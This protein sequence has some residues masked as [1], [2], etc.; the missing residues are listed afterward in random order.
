M[1]SGCCLESG[2]LSSWL[3]TL[4]FVSLFHM[5]YVLN[6]FLMWCRSTRFIANCCVLDRSCKIKTW[7]KF[8]LWQ[9]QG[10]AQTNKEYWRKVESINYYIISLYVLALNIQEVVSWC[11]YCLFSC[12]PFVILEYKVT[13]EFKLFFIITSLRRKVGVLNI[14]LSFAQC[15][16]CL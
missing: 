16:I 6:F 12:S 11:P 13:W 2:K 10:K 9:K 14:K 5:L 4:F 3:S 1:Y 7:K 15:Y 8:E